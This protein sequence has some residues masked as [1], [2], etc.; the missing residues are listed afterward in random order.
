[1]GATLVSVFMGTPRF[2]VP[3]L[4]ALS[5]ATRIALVVTQPDRPAGRGRV[6]EP[7]PIKVAAEALGIEVAQPAVVKGRRFADRIASLGP[8]LLVTAAFGR[9]LG[10]SLLAVPRFGCLNVHASLLPRHRGA[11]PINRAILAGDERTGVS[12]IGMVEQLDAGPVYHAVETEI[13][14]DETAGELSERLALLG[15]E[16]LRHVIAHVGEIEPAEQDPAGVSWAPSLAKADGAIDWSRTAAELHDH[17]RG[18]HPWP[19]AATVLDGEPLKVHRARVAA[20][21]SGP[22]R[23]GTVLAHSAAGLDVACGDGALRLLALQLP[24]RKRLDAAQFHA[25]RRVD[26]GTV[27]G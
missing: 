9:L 10:R 12:I 21:M 25:G 19:C 26:V 15:A 13:G 2:A 24:G 4:E 27:L 3:A 20:D 23:P 18:M 22:S 8:D 17:V 14:P 1:V 7:P 5:E 16:A 6:L 11:A